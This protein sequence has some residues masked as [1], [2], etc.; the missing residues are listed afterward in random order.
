MDTSPAVLSGKVTNAAGEPIPAAVVRIA[1][2]ATD[3]RFV[4]PTSGHRQMEVRTDADGTYR[5]EIPETTTSTML[6]RPL[7]A[8]GTVAVQRPSRIV[9]HYLQPEQRDVLLEGDQ[10]T[11]SWPSPTVSK[12]VRSGS[13]CS[14][15]WS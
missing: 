12:T 1:V 11:V 13:S 8:T 3:M 2:P 10:M 14:R 9:L 7:I 15:C 4:D 5:F 6:T